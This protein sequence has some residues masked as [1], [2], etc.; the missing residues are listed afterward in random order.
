V[1]ALEPGN[2][3]ALYQRGVASEQLG[4]IDA[5]VADFSAVLRLDGSHAKALYARG[6]CHNL[7]GDFA[8][9]VGG[10]SSPIAV[11]VQLLHAVT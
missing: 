9:A 4:C 11:H 2:V 6:A 8:R 7:Q 3:D 1:L 10:A 5:A